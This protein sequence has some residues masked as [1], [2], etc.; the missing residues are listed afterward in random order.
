MKVGDKINVRYD[1]EILPAHVTEILPDGSYKARLESGEEKVFLRNV[2]WPQHIH[3]VTIEVK[4]GLD[5]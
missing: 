1:G 3:P 5:V 2:V 4:G